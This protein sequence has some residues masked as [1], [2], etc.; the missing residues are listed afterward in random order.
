MQKII[1]LIFSQIVIY[2]LVNKKRLYRI[3]NNNINNFI[4][5]ND[6]ENVIRKKKFIT[7]IFNNVINCF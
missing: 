4:V 3:D 7:S 1:S 2:M 6:I 5:E